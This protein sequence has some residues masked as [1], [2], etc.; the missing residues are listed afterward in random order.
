MRHLILLMSAL[1]VLSVLAGCG[2]EK[3]KAVEV[4]HNPD[5]SF[6]AALKLIDYRPVSVFKSTDIRKASF[7]V[8][9]MHSHAYVET[10]EGVADWVKLLDE[11]NIEKVIILTNATG[12]DFDRIY[13]LYKS[14]APERFEIWCSFDMASLGTDEYPDKALAELERCHKKGASGVGE[15]L[16]KGEGEIN[17]AKIKKGIHIDDDIFIP[18]FS[19]CAELGMPVNMHVADPIWMYQSI[20]EHNDGYPNALEWKIDTTKQ[21]VLGFNGMIKTLTRAC[22]KNPG[23]TF[24]AC[25]L[26]N[27]SH[28]YETLGKA[29]DENPNLMIDISARF[30]ETAITPRATA[31]FYTKYSERIFFG[32]DNFP[33]DAMYDVH[34]RILESADEHFYYKYPTYH[35]ALHGFDLDERTLKNIYRDN[36]LKL[37][38]S[39]GKMNYS[40]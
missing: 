24:I 36:A 12:K 11:N 14:V 32:T 25:H 39:L 30:Q 8:I 16:D 37:Y 34:W 28:D 20:D 1:S 21:G 19:K 9:D 27:L 38:R 23:T 31:G 17:S 15:L 7:P 18:L 2:Y 22:K 6:F 33:I 10:S 3:K 26:M 35:W 29:L 4:S 40:K 5:S 13:D